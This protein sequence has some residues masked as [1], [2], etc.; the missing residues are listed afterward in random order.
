MLFRLFYLHRRDFCYNIACTVLCERSGIIVKF[1]K[2][3]E[4]PRFT[5]RALLVFLLPV[6]FEQLMMSG[7]GIADTFMVSFLG[8]EAVAGV[9]LVNRID[10]FAKQFFLAMAQGGSVLLSMYIG[11]KDQKQAEN[12]LKTNI[13]I[14]IAFGLA[15]MLVMVGFREQVLRLL[16]GNADPAVLA[17]SNSYFTVTALSYPFIALYYAGTAS[18]RAMGES[19]LPSMASIAMMCV[20]LLLKFLFIFVFQ[21]GVTGAALS[22]LMAMGTVGFTLMFMLRRKKN[23]VVLHGLLKPD[24][25]PGAAKRIL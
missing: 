4:N 9:A 20:N 14:V 18:F 1:F 21:M 25:D 23:K 24:F 2:L 19:R 8:E 22:T 16:F 5:N 7:L 12:A 11:A 3:P 6:L 15:V 13:R 17:Y 10:N